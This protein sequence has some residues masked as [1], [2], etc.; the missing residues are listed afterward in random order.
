MTHIGLRIGIRSQIR[1]QATSGISVHVGHILNYLGDHLCSPD[2]N[3]FKIYG[4]GVAHNAHM[5]DDLDNHLCDENGN[6][7][8]LQ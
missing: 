8:T 5:L 3:Y 6:Y 1:I 7:F 2:G 4:T